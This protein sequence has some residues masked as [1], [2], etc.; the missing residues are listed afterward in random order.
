MK[1][2]KD[3]QI[4]DIQEAN[5]TDAEALSAFLNQVKKEAHFVV[6]KDSGIQLEEEKLIDYLKHLKVLTTSK[7]FLGKVNNDIIASGG[8]YHRETSVVGNVDLDLNVIN[9]YINLGTVEYMLNHV[10]NYAR[11]TTEIDSIDILI[12][13]NDRLIKIIKSLGFKEISSRKA[14]VALDVLKNELVFRLEL[15]KN[16]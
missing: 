10:I 9:D 11:I 5:E 2:L 4:L 7:L 6:L 8:I 14:D 12:Y 3:N 16:R 15:Q 1:F 13:K